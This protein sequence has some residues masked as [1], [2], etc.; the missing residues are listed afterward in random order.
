MYEI[1]ETV[2][3]TVPDIPDSDL[4]QIKTKFEKAAKKEKGEIVKAEDWGVKKLAY[5][6][7]HNKKGKYVCY[8]YKAAPTSISEI[9]RNL[10]LDERV[11]RFLTFKVDPEDLEPKKEAE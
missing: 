9:E 5:E 4:K 11:I 10:K 3:I 6:I 8:N 1:Y 7:K 2:F